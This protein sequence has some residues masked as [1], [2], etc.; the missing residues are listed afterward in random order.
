MASMPAPVNRS[1]TAAVLVPL[2][3]PQ[4]AIGTALLNAAQLAMFEI[5]DDTFTLLPFDTKGTPEGAVAAA[6]AAVAQHAD[7]VI[8]P[9]FAGEAKAAAMVTRQSGLNMVS[10]TSDRTA[11]GDGVYTLGFLPGPQAVQV[12]E[13]ARSQNRPRLAILAPSNEY[14]RRVA[15]WLYNTPSVA[16]AI[17]SVQY[18]DPAAP[19]FTGP[20]KR[21]IKTDPKKP[22]DVGFDALLLPDEGARLRGIAS[23]LS[24]QGIDPV[25][26]KLLGTMLWEDAKPNSEPALSGGWYAAP[27]MAGHADFDARYAR[28]FG[29]RPPR[30]ASL[31]YDATALAA[32]L[33]RRSPHD[34]TAAVLTNPLGF[35]GVD[36][37]FRLLADGTSER[38][39][40]IDEVVPGAPAREIAPAPASFSAAY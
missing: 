38:G 16:P 25:Q 11:V 2:S 19:D 3:G 35:A 37:L 32:V 1:A 24:S 5:G 8:G 6:Q 9:L 27:A 14:G 28:A 20:I 30:I 39:Y 21:L 4:A 10:F 12:V 13:Y 23:M 22:G 34:F 29:S 17:A 36:G 40:A 7:I 18:Y 33:A 15:E 26:V 31:G